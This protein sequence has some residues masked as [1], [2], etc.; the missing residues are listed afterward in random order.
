MQNAFGIEDNY[1][2]TGIRQGDPLGA[3]Y[4]I[5]DTI[6]ADVWHRLLPAS[7]AGQVV[8]DS[9]SE[10]NE[11]LNIGTLRADIENIPLK[12]WQLL[13]L[14]NG[15]Q[16]QY[17]IRS[18]DAATNIVQLGRNYTTNEMMK[19]HHIPNPVQFVIFPTHIID[20][21][22]CFDDTATDTIEIGWQPFNVYA[23]ANIV[24]MGVIS[25]G[26]LMAIPAQRVDRLV[27]RFDTV[28]SGAKNYLTWGEHYIA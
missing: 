18:Y 15:Y 13:V 28:T 12:G 11:K 9:V 20:F 22:I 16:E 27:F 23:P 8:A 7:D 26:K 24:Q 3:Y 19:L 4:K 2:E 5:P 6:T 10:Y 14:N 21:K 17:T 25:P 1:R